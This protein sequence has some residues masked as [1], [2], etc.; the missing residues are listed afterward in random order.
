MGPHKQG[1]YFSCYFPTIHSFAPPLSSTAKSLRECNSY[2]IV[3]RIRNLYWI[4]WNIIRCVRKLSNQAFKDKL[5]CV[6]NISFLFRIWTPNIPGLVYPEDVVSQNKHCERIDLEDE[7]HPVWKRIVYFRWHPTRSSL[8]NVQL[9]NLEIWELRLGFVEY[10]TFQSK[11]SLC[12]RLIDLI[13]HN[14]GANFSSKENLSPSFSQVKDG[15]FMH[16]NIG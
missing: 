8:E 5:S 9:F 13:P 11:L 7:F 12:S 10:N 1:F 15:I 6:L 2:W 3:C 4:N 16:G 14:R